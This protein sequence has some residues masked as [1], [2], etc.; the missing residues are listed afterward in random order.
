M[1]DERLIDD[2]WG[3]VSW[4][5]SQSSHGVVQKKHDESICDP[6]GCDYSEGVRSKVSHQPFAIES[7]LAVID[8]NTVLFA[9]YHFILLGLREEENWVCDGR[10]LADPR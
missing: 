8:I 9:R 3:L 2:C 4:K 1:S 6:K 5:L 10:F 7:T